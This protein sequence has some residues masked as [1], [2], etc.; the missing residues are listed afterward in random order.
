MTL[1]QQRQWQILYKAMYV[2]LGL[3]LKHQEGGLSPRAQR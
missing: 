2:A 3:C 1:S